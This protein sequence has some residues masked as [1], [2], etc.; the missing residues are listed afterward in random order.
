MLNATMIQQMWKDLA[1]A[2]HARLLLKSRSLLMRLAGAFLAALRIQKPGEFIQ[3]Y[4]TTIGRR[5]YLPF[6][7]GDAK[8]CPLWHQVVLCAHELRHVEQFQRE[9]F[10]RFATKYLLFPSARA[11]YEADALQC[12]VELFWLRT[13][14]LPNLENMAH[15]LTGYAFTK[16][17]Q[18][19]VF[20]LL[21]QSA[22]RIL[23]GQFQDF[24]SRSA[25]AWLASPGDFPASDFKLTFEMISRIRMQIECLLPSSPMHATEV[26]KTR[27]PED[28]TFL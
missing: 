12:N 4:A 25:L 24:A 1:Q 10:I 5:I 21:Q 18:A 28:Q 23:K 8:A 9:G 11:R 15:S 14:Q 6:E 27:V 7:P 19:L 26:P 13:G 2:H 16:K 17:A 3:H 20:S 22:Q